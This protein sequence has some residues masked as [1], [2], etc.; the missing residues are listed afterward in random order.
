MHD[1][2]RPE[3][4]PPPSPKNARFLD[5]E[6]TQ[7]LKGEADQ[8]VKRAFHSLLEEAAK[9]RLKERW[10]DRIEGLARLAVDQFLNELDSSLGVEAILERQARASQATES[11]L[12][13]LFRGSAKRE[14]G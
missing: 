2:Q 10:G 13:D 11:E 7:M 8:V 4:G 9:A 6:P 1:Q 3:G 5:L 12:A 14:P